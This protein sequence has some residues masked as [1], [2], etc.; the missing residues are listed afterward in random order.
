MAATATQQIIH[1]GAR[2]LVLK[3]TIGGTADA[4]AAADVLVDASVLDAALVG[5][6]LLRLEK[7]VWSLTGFSCKLLWDDEDSNVDLIELTQGGGEL[8]FTDLGGLVNNAANATG[9]VLFTTTGYDTAGDGGHIILFFK[10]KGLN[11]ES[12]NVYPAAAS[13]ALTG[14]LPTIAIA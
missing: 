7:A 9:D 12:P 1:N 8:D 6:R 2:N 3:Y 11:T 14:I 13:L 10:K 5:N 4:D